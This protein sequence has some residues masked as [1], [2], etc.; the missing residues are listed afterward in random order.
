ME[1]TDNWWCDYIGS[2]TYAELINNGYKVVIMDNLVNSSWDVDG[3]ICY[4]NPK[5][6]YE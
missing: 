5:S 4:A 1:N 2:H 6:V 3:N